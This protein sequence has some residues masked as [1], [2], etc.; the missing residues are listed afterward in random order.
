MY[1]I[2]FKSFEEQNSYQLS[3]QIHITDVQFR[4]LLLT[5]WAP[6]AV[7]I[8]ICNRRLSK[9]IP[10]ET[11]NVCIGPRNL[12]NQ[13]M[14]LL[15]LDKEIK[16]SFTRSRQRNTFINKLIRAFAE[17]EEELLFSR[18]RNS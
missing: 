12:E 4:Y 2:D 7:Y 6:E 10:Y 9:Y 11:M 1:Y 13:K 16:F 18:E 3:I 5:H 15:E 17:L 14:V 8:H